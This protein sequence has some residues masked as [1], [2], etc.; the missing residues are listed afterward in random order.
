MRGEVSLS[1]LKLYAGRGGKKV[2]F[3]E[4]KKPRHVHSRKRADSPEK[5][6]AGKQKTYP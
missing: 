3:P 4:P 1:A 6:K 2:E 5:R